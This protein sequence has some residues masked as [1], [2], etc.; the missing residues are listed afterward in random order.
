MC[1]DDVYCIDS[2]VLYKIRDAISL[3]RSVIRDILWWRW[4]CLGWSIYTSPCVPLTCSVTTLK[5]KEVNDKYPI[6]TTNQCEGDGSPET[7]EPHHRLHP[8]WYQLASRKE[9]VIYLYLSNRKDTRNLNK[10]ANIDSG[11]MLNSLLN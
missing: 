5:I 9:V 2:I 7:C 6:R 11:N 10:L 4:R 1:I 3:K 8:H